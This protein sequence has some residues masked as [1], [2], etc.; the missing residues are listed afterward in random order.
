MKQ[1]KLELKPH[2]LKAVEDMHNGCV[3]WGGVGSGKTLTA[4]SYALKK[5]AGKKIYVITTAKKRDS[6][7]WQLE[8]AMLG[9]PFDDMVVDSWNNI[10]KYTDVYDAFFIFD[11]QRLVGQGAWVKSF[12][13]IAKLNRWVLLSATPGDSWLDYV[14]VFIAN[15]FYKNITEFRRDHVIYKRFGTYPVVERFIGEKRLLRLRSLVLV[16]MPVKRDTTRHVTVVDVPYDKTRFDDALK[17][18]WNIFEDA[19]MMN[20]AE[21]FRVGRQIVGEDPAKLDKVRELMNKHPRLIIFYNYDY[22]LKM[23]RKLAWERNFAEWN[24][25]K[26]EPI[27]DTDYWLYAVQYVAGAEGWNCITTDAM[28]FYSLT[29]SYKNFEQAQGRIDRLN[30]VYMDLHYYVLMSKAMTDRVVWKALGQKKD[31]QP[32]RKKFDVK[33]EKKQTGL[34]YAN[35]SK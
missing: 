34:N 21:M 32:P 27:P 29:Y 1:I 25:H 15:G 19:P 30:N 16:E 31:F 14:P 18:R 35:T 11:E 12:Y 10:G 26:H 33:P 8:A 9:I 3:L 28:I 22:E 2:Q 23:L 5:E 17:R 6:C 20:V 4:L 13:T 24:G 7:D